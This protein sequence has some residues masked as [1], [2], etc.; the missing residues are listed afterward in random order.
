MAIAAAVTAAN[1]YYCQ[2]LL[3]QIA[4]SLHMTAR[5]TERLVGRY[6]WAEMGT[7]LYFVSRGSQLFATEPPE[8]PGVPTR[9]VPTENRHVFIAADGR[10]T[11][12]PIEFQVAADGTVTG[13]LW[14][15]AFP[16]RR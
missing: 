13:C 10:A 9:L 14:V 11:G 1:L 8:I 6:L 12:E 4:R 2:P 7:L 5:E 15:C 16:Y 3:S